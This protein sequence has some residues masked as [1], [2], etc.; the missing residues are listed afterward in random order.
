MEI[1]TAKSIQSLMKTKEW[2]EVMVVFQKYIAD[3]DNKGSIK[4]DTEFDT[5]WHLAYNEGGKYYL[6]DFINLLDKIALSYVG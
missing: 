6:N 3:M 1:K 2:E 5:I 4:K